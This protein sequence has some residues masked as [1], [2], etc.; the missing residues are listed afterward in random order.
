MGNKRDSGIS[1]IL[2]KY[3]SLYEQEPQALRLEA[4]NLKLQAA[5]LIGV[6]RRSSSRK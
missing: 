4:L 3:H 2:T 1:T 6:E 5:I